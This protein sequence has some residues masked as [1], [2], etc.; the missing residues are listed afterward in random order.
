MSLDTKITKLLELIKECGSVVVAFSGGVDSTFLAA[1]A[2]RAV[3]DKAIAVTACSETLPESER[4]EAIEF[5]DNIGIKH[6]LLNISELESTDFVANDAKRCYYCK[7][8]RLGAIA[9][10]GKA[11][12]YEWVLEGSNADDTSDYRPGLQAVE[13]MA[14]VRSPLLEA[15]LTKAEIREISQQW[16][17]PTWDKPSAACLSSRIVYGLPVTA[18]RLKQVE[19]AEAFVRK[20]CSNQIRVRHH[21]NMARIEVSSQDIPVLAQPNTAAAI[22]SELKKLGFT[23]VV[24]DLQGYRTGSMNE[25]LNK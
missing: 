10:W 19:F 5:A 23:F 20:F 4:S 2:A 6:Q 14:G 25:V 7:K 22:T 17:L 15:G 11:Q 8:Q 3:G 13:E 21:G 9:V 24:L 18:E 16:G 12:G 1:A